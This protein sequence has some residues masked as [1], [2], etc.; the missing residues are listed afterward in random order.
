M[1]IEYPQEIKCYKAKKYDWEFFTGL[2][3]GDT[4]LDNQIDIFDLYNISDFIRH[5]SENLPLYYL[6][7]Y[8][9]NRDGQMTGTDVERIVINILGG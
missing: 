3:L 6:C 1:E 5:D 7:K 4:N 8:D 9:L 2:L